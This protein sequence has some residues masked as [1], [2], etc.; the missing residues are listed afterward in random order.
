MT[1][2]LVKLAFAG[3]RSRLLASALT[4]VLCSAAAATIV[5]AL[6]VGSTMRDPWQRTFTEANGAHVLANVASSADANKLADLPGVSQ[7]D[8]PIPNANAAVVGT[9]H[10]QLAGLLSAATI[11]KP[12]PIDGTTQPGDGIVLERSFADALGFTVGT[13]VRLAGPRG[14]VELRVGG[15]GGLPQP[16]ALPAPQPRPGLGLPDHTRTG[17][18]GHESLA[19]DRGCPAE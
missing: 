9:D 2:T 14:P 4:V 15:Y 8:E 1:L 12:V 18:A 6:E 17:P 11:N 10:L 5:L 3:L 16:T 13:T 7:R 19:V